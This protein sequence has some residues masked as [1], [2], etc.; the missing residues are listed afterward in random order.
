[1]RRRKQA[2]SV[3]MA[4]IL[5]AGSLSGFAGA[6][7]VRAADAQFAGEE[8]YDQIGTVEVNREPAHTYFT[9]YE[10]AEKAL[11]NERSVLDTD[12]EESA[13]KISL[14]GEW[15][16]KF[17]GKPADR[18]KD[19]N[20]KAAAGYR[21]NWDTQDW[22]TI[23][24]P[25]S[26]Q[27]VKDEEGYFKYEKPIYTNQ[28]YP[29]QNYEKV[30]LGEAVT[31]PTVRNSVGQYK[32]T[33]TVPEEWDGREVF[34]SF[35]GVESAFYL[36]V[37]GKRVGYAED[38]YTTDEFN[39][40]GYLK[41]GENTIAAEVYRWS[42][43]S[44]LENQD[45]IRYSG[46]FRDVNLY[47][48]NRVELRDVFIKTDLDDDYENA[49]LTLEAA[50]RNLGSDAETGK[51]YQVT[52][53][54]YEIDGV[55]KVWTKPLTMQVTVPQ[56]KAS[57]EER[58]D[59]EGT[60]VTG[61]K[62]VINPKKWFADTPN[63]YLLLI[64]LRDSGGNTV[65]TVCQRVGFREIGKMD[66]NEA[67]QEQMQINGKK[68]MFRGTN[69]HET[70]L[71]DGRAITR[72]AVTEDLFL[73]KQFNVNAIRTSHYPN[74]PYTYAL[75]DEIGIYICDETNIESHMGATQSDIP[76]GY[77]VWNTSVLDRAKNMVERDKNHPCVV[78][79]SLGNEATYKTYPMDE[80]YCMYQSTRWILERDPSRLRKYERDNRYT[81]GDREN[82]MVDIY[83]SQYWS[84]GS[85]AGHVAN[86]GNKAPYIQSEYAHAMGNALGNFKEY[87]DV[88]RSYPNAQGGFIWDWIDQS[89]RTKAEAQESA[90]CYVLDPNTG[91]R[92]RVQA[93]VTGGRNGTLALEGTYQ[94]AGSGALAADSSRGLTVDVWLKPAKDYTVAQQTFISRGDDAG[95]NLQIDKEGNFEFFV[96][97]W[98]GGV[99]TAPVPESFTDGEWHRLT[100]VYAGT[101]YVLYYDGK[102]I[103]TGTRE[104]LSV[105][106]SSSNTLD[107]TIGASADISG[108][109]FN[110]AI[111]RAAV[112]RGALGTEQI[113]ATKDDLD[114]VKE[115]VVYA[116]DYTE[117]I[118]EAE[119]TGTD[120]E[121]YFGYGGDWGETVTDNDFCANGLVFA[122]RTPSPELYEVKK[123]HQEISFYDDG[124]AA[125]GEVR[126]VN[127]F[128]NTNLNRYDVSWTLKENNTLLGS[129]VL[130]EG[131]KDLE[132]QQE[133]TVKLAGFPKV[134][135]TEGLDYILTLSVT[136]KEDQAWAGAYSGH[137]GDE[138][139]FEEF[140]LSYDTVQ[141][142]PVLDASSMGE[143]NVQDEEEQL[144]VTGKTG[145][146]SFEITVDKRTGYISTY[147]V[148]GKL[149]LE[150]GPVPNYYRAPVNN[151]P[152][153]AQEMKNAA[154][155]FTVDAGGIQVTAKKKIVSVHV[156]GRIAGLDSEDVLHYDIYGNG[157]VV[158]T[159]TFTPSGSVGNI[160]RIG[161]K[162]TV[163]EGY[164]NL[165]YYGNGPQ[166]NYSDRNTGT[167][168]GVYTSTVT[169]QFE[170]KYI[171]PQENGNRTGVRWT[172][173]TNEQGEGLLVTADG[174][175]ESGALHYRAEDLASYRHPYQV[176]KQK[177]TILT[178]DLVQRGLGNASCG[179]GPLS[180]YL[181]PGGTTYSQT[182]CLS[183]VLAGTGTEEWMADSHVNINSGM[184][185]TGIKING[186]EISGFSAGKTE[187]EYTLLKG[188][189]EE[190]TIPQAEG[191][192]MS[193][194]VQVTVTQAEK[195]PGTV[196]IRAVSPFGAEMTYRIHIRVEDKLYVSDME[197]AKDVGGYYPNARDLCSCGAEMA[198]YVDGQRKTYQK[199][200]GS[201]APSQVDIDLTGK[202][203]TIFRAQAGISACQS[204]GN[205]A[206]VNFT[207]K[208]DGKEI[209]RQNGVRSGQSYPVKLDVSGV[210]LL[211]LITETNGPDSNDH[212]IWADARL[213]AADEILITGIALAEKEAELYPGE[214]YSVQASVLPE[215]TTQERTLTYTSSDRTVASVDEK[216]LVTAYKEGRTVI[217]V[218]STADSKITAKMTVTVKKKDETEDE[219]DRRKLQSALETARTR[220][221][222]GYT[223]ES[224]QKYRTAVAEAEKVLADEKASREEID[225]AWQA[226]REAEAGLKKKE[227]GGQKPDDEK[228]GTDL[229]EKEV[230][231]AGK[232]YD[233]KNGL[234]Y[235][236]TKAA[237]SGGT[238]TVVKLLKKD[239][240]RV[241]IPDE[242]K[243]DGCVFRVTAVSAGACKGC[244]KLKAVTIGRNVTR[245]GKRAFYKCKKLKT[246]TFKGRKAPKAGKQSFQGIAAKARIF[247]PGNMAKKQ[248]KLLK[249]RMKKS[250]AGGKI[251]Y[252]RKSR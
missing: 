125:D 8:W 14:N 47:S 42:T 120:A 3:F 10:S 124:K 45:F 229:P 68:I 86:T 41:E 166:E 133:K 239:K 87:W 167:K 34:V 168:L 205:P 39:I 149:L 127:E 164:E 180:E 182:F 111:D 37:N 114:A 221:L 138:I 94:A 19:L 79:W 104:A 214:T 11:A 217:T 228:P 35:E 188:S 52:A 91:K 177:N 4:G 82:S 25:S 246:V 209:F 155:N 23:Q 189:F 122:D 252:K 89:M 71:D 109:R 147:K 74:Q 9:P 33:F 129:G 219:T 158:V 235:R 216:G 55:T 88:F 207:V 222:S 172:A 232:I 224:A 178:V 171:K 153:F 48:K 183:P 102:Q 165:T 160:A 108:R 184:P 237:A 186:T 50:V 16:F 236:V 69:R 203:I 162:M 24:V 150:N 251:L 63:L 142:Q 230:P 128:L 143:L 49:V 62:E 118:V 121:T 211:S 202:G 15:K 51:Q 192:K 208:A 136:L 31:A 2:W 187:Y 213:L 126:V 59:D 105:C 154:E 17:A 78:I 195:L 225:A 244:R 231:E 175:M 80:T 53:D 227:A 92:T 169:E 174:V 197:W 110:G 115:D 241:V 72:E 106:D 206:D 193:E 233:G 223:E 132:P 6:L 40:T 32:R 77:P 12:E 240:V 30:S 65:E 163:A 157:Q 97:G 194:D 38:S 96:D 123:V 60:T 61:S 1:M 243:L 44:Y 226:L 250:G 22:D 28:T 57:A 27:A 58:A 56:A 93:A 220:D 103:G 247:V 146:Q 151:D 7:P 199:G 137:A 140:E 210:K 215:H 148:N 100:A 130:T 159:N 81:K 54:L 135:A 13:Y 90:V 201:H 181:I 249:A 234:R 173:L 218:A 18:E 64:R 98:R 141:K 190:G 185:L 144:T 85:V 117:D 107:I 245:I 119:D 134:R 70:D 101:E 131:Q 152:S 248:L 212:A 112:I 191:I 156:P 73:M 113:E 84:V 170:S 196:V 26:I 161:M 66:I 75:A 116:I 76:S 5:L 29:W 242:V 204:I 20:G 179:P 46:I 36:Y 43:G 99:V 238:V 198:V 139:A 200:V 145:G 67:G 95:Y 83:S 21:E 176:P